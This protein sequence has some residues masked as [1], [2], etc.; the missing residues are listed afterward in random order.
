MVLSPVTLGARN[1][2]CHPLQYHLL[3]IGVV[4]FCS[5]VFASPNEIEEAHD[6]ALRKKIQLNHYVVEAQISQFLFQVNISTN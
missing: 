5:D 2:R 3:C 1:F 4:V 6:L